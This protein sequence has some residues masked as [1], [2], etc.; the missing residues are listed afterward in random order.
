MNHIKIRNLLVGLMTLVI[1]AGVTGQGLHLMPGSNMIMTGPVN[2]VMNNTGFT[3]D[4]NFI[5]NSSSV[6]FTGTAPRSSSFIG[7]NSISSFNNITISKSANDMYLDKNISVTGIITMSTGNLVLNT[8][9]VNLG[10]TGKI[11]GESNQSHITDVSVNGSV[12]ASGKQVANTPFNPGNMGLELLTSQS[13]GVLTFDRRHFA[14][15]LSGG[16]GQS[17]QRS[18]TISGAKNP[19]NV[20]VRLRIFYLDAELAGNDE[21][22]LL[23]WA[24]SGAGNFLVPIGKDFNST[25]ENWVIK[26]HV[27][28][29]GHFTLASDAVVAFGT[30]NSNAKNKLSDAY[31]KSSARIYP[32][33][34]NDQFTIELV[35]KKQQDMVIGLYDEAGHLVQQKQINCIA[36]VNH[37]SWNL[38]KN[39][40]GTY[41][42]SFSDKEV[43]TIKIVKE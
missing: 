12:T 9:S 34:A 22:S 2:L 7:G 5:A 43:G 35:S 11:A 39:T 42:L 30:A 25:T 32:N 20:N 23:F 6:L 38:A 13:L 24:T 4:G 28:Q 8:H 19:N 14:E 40:A 21:S 41:Y 29:L 15:S 26:D 31:H 27:T 36:G 1:P 10:T 17:I 18:F 37:V 16:S 3:N 33:P